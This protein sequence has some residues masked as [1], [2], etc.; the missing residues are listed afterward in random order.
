[1]AS[2]P[3]LTPDQRLVEEVP[4]ITGS[5]RGERREAGRRPFLLVELGHVRF[6]ASLV[7]DYLAPA[8]APGR[9][10]DRIVRTGRTQQR[11]GDADGAARRGRS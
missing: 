5:T 1:M 9:R 3:V 7:V 6:L 11:P 2:R 4:I 10:V 8:G